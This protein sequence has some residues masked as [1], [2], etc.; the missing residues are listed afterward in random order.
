MFFASK[1]VWVI[2]CSEVDV[3]LDS[4]GTALSE[5]ALKVSHRVNAMIKL[6]LGGKTHTD[7]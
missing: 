2:K 6:V 4:C 3:A 5:L 7:D 1:N